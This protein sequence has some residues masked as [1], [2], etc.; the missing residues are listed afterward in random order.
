MEQID[1]KLEDVLCKLLD[2]R[3]TADSSSEEGK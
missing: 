1:S 3:K 2:A